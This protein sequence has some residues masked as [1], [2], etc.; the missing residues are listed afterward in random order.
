M[1]EFKHPT[2]GNL[3][4]REEDEAWC[5]N[6]RF[7]FLMRFSYPEGDAPSDLVDVLIEGSPTETKPSEELV[8]VADQCLANFQ[9][10]VFSAMDH[11]IRDIDG[12]GPDSGV[13]WHDELEQVLDIINEET[14]QPLALKSRDDLFRLL[15]PPD[16]RVQPYG[17]GFNK[18]CGIIGCESAIDI[19]HG[20]G[21]LTNGTRILG[22]GQRSDPS[23][24]EE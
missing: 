18:P 12:N 19:E 16:L 23:P 11:L 17:Y 6:A 3:A 20:V 21:W 24:F 22:L 9:D 5:G 4:Y 15:T 1:P 2:L 7:D 14:S 13:W 8:A 10:L